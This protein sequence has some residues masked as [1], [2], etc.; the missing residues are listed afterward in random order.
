VD[1]TGRAVREIGGAVWRRASRPRAWATDLRGAQGEPRLVTRG[2]FSRA[3]NVDVIPRSEP[4][5][6]IHRK[7]YHTPD[8]DR[9]T[10]RANTGSSPTPVTKSPRGRANIHIAG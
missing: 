1:H 7:R 8:N 9:R 6:H 4:A 10:C 3:V 2:A 5:L